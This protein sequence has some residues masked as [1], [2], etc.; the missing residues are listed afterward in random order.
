[1]S[2]P[3][4]ELC[5]LVADVVLAQAAK[6]AA[7]LEGFLS[8]EPQVLLNAKGRDTVFLGLAFTGW[9][10]ANGAWSNLQI[11]KL[12]RDLMETSKQALALKAATKLSGSQEARNVAALAAGIDEQLQSYFKS[13]L[14]RMKRLE[15]S[16]Q[17]AD[18]NS[19]ML[20][21]LEWIQG[22]LNIPDSVMNRLVP[23]L[24]GLGTFEDFAEAV[25]SVA[26]Q[27]NRVASE[28]EKRGCLSRFF[29]P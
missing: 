15:E 2:S 7:Q 1:M 27:V 9:A 29:F 28:R 23:L 17:S 12:R 26:A 6:V 25:E 13:Y 5:D 10:F 22:N 8:Q 20:F 14:E 4:H 19:A 21:G 16:N 3:L 11:T 24:V 18:A